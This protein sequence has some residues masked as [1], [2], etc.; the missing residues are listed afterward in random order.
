M[1]Q[2]TCC[3]CHSLLRLRAVG[4]RTRIK[5]PKCNDHFYLNPDGRIESRLEGNTTAIFQA[6]VGGLNPLTPP[7]GIAPLEQLAPHDKTQPI[8][9]GEV[10][11]VAKTQPIRRDAIGATLDLMA[12][13]P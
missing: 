2:F 11:G 6:D 10:P 7:P 3:Y 9:R 12:A 5:C 8:R 4:K 13:V 1:V